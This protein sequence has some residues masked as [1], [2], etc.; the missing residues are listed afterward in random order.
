MSI[1]YTVE[2]SRTVYDL[3]ITVTTRLENGWQLVG[4]VCVIALDC[5]MMFDYAQAL[6]RYTGK[7]AK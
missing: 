6:V 7:D 5:G 4:G 1:E 3:S 2:K